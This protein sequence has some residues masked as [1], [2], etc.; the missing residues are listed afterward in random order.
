VTYPRSLDEISDEELRAE[1]LRR[2]ELRRKNRCAYCKGMKGV[3]PSCRRKEEHTAYVEPS[4]VEK[5]KARDDALRLAKEGVHGKLCKA[6]RVE[7]NDNVSTLLWYVVEGASVYWADKSS[8][9]ALQSAEP[10]KA[11]VFGGWNRIT[12]TPGGGYQLHRYSST[13][14]F[15]TRYLMIGP[16]PAGWY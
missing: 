3:E 2:D 10:G 1:L 9:F 16:N 8:D 12:Y 14:D 13:D 7:D 15:I 5:E 11:I 6:F 4:Q